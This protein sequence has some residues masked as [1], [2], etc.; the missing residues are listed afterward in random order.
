MP[1]YYKTDELSSWLGGAALCLLVVGYLALVFYAP[2]QKT[3]TEGE[4]AALK[5]ARL[6][7]AQVLQARLTGSSELS[8]ALDATLS[9][10]AE[11]KSGS[12]D[13]IH[14]LVLDCPPISKEGKYQYVQMPDGTFKRFSA[15]TSESQIMMA[16]AKDFPACM[17]NSTTGKLEPAPSRKS[18]RIIDLT[19]SQESATAGENGAASK[20]NPPPASAV[21][22][23]EPRGGKNL[24]IYLRKSDF[25]TV[26][27]PD[28]KE[29]V[30]AVGKAWCDN[31]GEDSHWLLPSVYIGDI[32]TGEELARYSCVFD[33]VSW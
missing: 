32:R 8:E 15:A 22:R 26:L 16:I 5:K 27:Y 28:R 3:F 20:D 17:H 23:I 21:L 2:R 31:T 11:A 9:E 1:N 19:T 18:E 6:A 14:F 4:R 12:H 29:F 10:G 24:V 13:D 33:S 25:E 7:V 30:R